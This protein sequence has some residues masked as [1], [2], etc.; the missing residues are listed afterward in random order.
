MVHL[1]NQQI[2]TGYMQ[3]AKNMI[4]NSAWATPAKTFNVFIVASSPVSNPNIHSII[5][6]IVYSSMSRGI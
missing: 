6:Y 4:P 5:L 3:Y 2:H 1:F